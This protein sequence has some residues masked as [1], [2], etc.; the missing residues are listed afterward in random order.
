VR[1][2]HTPAIIITS[3]H[4]TSRTEPDGERALF[5]VILL[6]TIVGANRRKNHRGVVG[7]LTRDQVPHRTA[8]LGAFGW[9]DGEGCAKCFPS[10]PQ[11]TALHCSLSGFSV[12][13][14]EVDRRTQHFYLCGSVFVAVCLSVSLSSPS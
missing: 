13:Q 8:H 11:L 3:R 14:V 2:R 5:C 4:V 10:P 12:V 6:Q 1:V 9:G 7:N